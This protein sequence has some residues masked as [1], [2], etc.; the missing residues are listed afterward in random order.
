MVSNKAARATSDVSSAAR[1]QQFV[2]MLPDERGGRLAGRERWVPQAG[3]EERL[4]GGD[5]ERDRVFKPM[6]ELAPRLIAGRRHEK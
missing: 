1:R 6:D 4:I 5:A 2:A 3:G